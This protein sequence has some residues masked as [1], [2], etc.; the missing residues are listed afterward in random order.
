M[1]IKSN[2]LSMDSIYK[3]AFVF[4]LSIAVSGGMNVSSASAQALDEIVVTA[5]KRE[6]SL[7]EVAAAVSAYSSDFLE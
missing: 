5:Q 7:Q 2:V 4:G 3:K 1:L 6:E